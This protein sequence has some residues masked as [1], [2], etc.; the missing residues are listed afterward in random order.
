[1][2]LFRSI[3]V[4]VGSTGLAAILLLSPTRE[5]TGQTAFRPFSS[6]GP[7]PTPE[8][9]ERFDRQRALLLEGW[10]VTPDEAVLLE[11]RL[12]KDSED[13]PL[14]L[15]L[16]SYYMQQVL[17]DKYAEHAFWLVEHHPDASEPEGSG[18]M[19]RIPALGKEGHA[20]L[21]N[22]LEALWR[23]Q[24]HR[25]AGDTRVLRN[26]ATALSPAQPALAMQYV[27][28]ARQAEPGNREW[29]TWL[30]KTYANGIRWTYWDGKSM[31]TFMSEVSDAR[32]YPFMLPLP[33]C[34][35]IKR[36]VETSTD[37]ALVGAVGEMLTREASLSEQEQVTPDVEQ[38]ARFGEVLTK[39]AHML[40]ATAGARR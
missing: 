8:M 16:M 9:I 12:A 27:K 40:Q 37:A 10:K 32:N 6:R 38:I 26:A 25:F 29:T 1:M 18:M 11:A 7:K 3:C 28:A 36:E 21:Q 31:M 35:E 15:R 22:R 23:E 34:Q 24:A 19:T 17:I 4:A 2:R 5:L 39:R 30:A 13:L 20:V 14:R 33:M